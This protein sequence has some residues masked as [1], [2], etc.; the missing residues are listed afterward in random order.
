[1]QGEFPAGFSV[2]FRRRTGRLADIRRQAGEFGLVTHVFGKGIGRIKQV[3]GE[4]RGQRVEFFLDRLKARLLFFRQ[5]G[6]GETE[7]T[8]FVVDDALAGG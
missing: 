3:F 2:L 8:H 7:I 1:M 4:L 6:A 5:F